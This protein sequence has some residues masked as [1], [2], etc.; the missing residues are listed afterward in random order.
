MKEIKLNHGYIAFVDDEDFEYLNKFN[1][2]IAK[3][4]G[5][6]YVQNNQKINNKWQPVLMHKIILNPPIGF[7]V[8]H[9]DMNGLNN[10]KINLRLCTSSQNSFNSLKTINKLGFK[11]IKIRKRKYKNEE[12]GE[13]IRFYARIKINGKEVTSKCCE[14]INEA[15]IERNELIKK[16]CKEF[17]RLIKI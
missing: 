14:D 9:I 4:N 2:S 17:G 15:I 11:N 1:W 7:R 13:W 16:H 10:Q 6:I 12:L 3:R 8:D 5:V